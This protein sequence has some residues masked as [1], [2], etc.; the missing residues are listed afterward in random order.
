MVQTSGTGL[1]VSEGLE[2]WSENQRVELRVNTQTLHPSTKASF[3][4][5]LETKTRYLFASSGPVG[6]RQ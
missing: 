5:E 2:G 4:S 1:E 6:L 3:R